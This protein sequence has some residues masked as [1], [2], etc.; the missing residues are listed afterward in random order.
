[1][2]I[3]HN[4][5]ESVN[6]VKANV[7]NGSLRFPGVSNVTLQFMCSMS[8][9]D[10]D[11]SPVSFKDPR[12]FPKSAFFVIPPAYFSENPSLA[13]MGSK[14][15]VFVLTFDGYEF[16]QESEEL[17]NLL[18]RKI[19]VVLCILNLEGVNFKI[20][21][22]YYV[23]ERVE[24]WIAD[25]NT[26]GIVSIF[27]QKLHEGVFSIEAPLSPSADGVFVNLLHCAVLLV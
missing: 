19:G 26:H 25:R 9:C 5:Q 21:S 17:S 3:G 24:A 6:S 7:L 11:V 8:A 23:R 10:V 2:G 16:I 20:L 27:L 22:G 4:T 14:H 12:F 15:S 1:M 18:F 13:Q